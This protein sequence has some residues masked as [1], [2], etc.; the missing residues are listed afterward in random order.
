MISGLSD[1]TLGIGSAIA[2]IVLGGSIIEK[3]F[4]LDNKKTVDSFFSLS[5]KNFKNMVK[6]IRRTELALGEINYN[7][8]YS[9]KKNLNSRRSIYISNNINNNEKISIFN[10]LANLNIF[11]C[12]SQG[13]YAL[14][15]KFHKF[16]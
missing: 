4:N 2:S 7:V 16:P 1:H 13:V 9:S 12:H 11:L 6:E 15:Y 14:L 5:A 10:F 8:S 3:H